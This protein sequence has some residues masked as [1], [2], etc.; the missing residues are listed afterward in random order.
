MAIRG[1]NLSEKEEFIHP[2]DSGHPDHADYKAAIKAGKE[3]EKPTVYF[4]GNLTANDRVEF[5]D[6]AATPTM[7]DGGITMALRN[8]AK[9]YAVVQ[10]GLKGWEN[11]IDNNGD[12]VAFKLGTAK[13]AMGE[14]VPAVDADVMV[15]LPQFVIIALQNEI[16][17]KNGMLAELA[18]KSED[19]LPLPDG[20]SS[21]IGPVTIAEPT[22]VTKEVVPNP[23]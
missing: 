5:G 2:D 15:H 7:R 4:I 12:A 17:R 9:A 11:Q 20:L 23:Q 3:P 8:V 10:R 13:N 18:K 1:V 14:F 22:S 16:L 21:E 6:M 19:Q